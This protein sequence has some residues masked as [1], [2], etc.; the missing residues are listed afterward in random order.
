M[1]TPISPTGPAKL[2]ALV[3]KLRPL[4]YGTLMAFSGELVHGAFLRWLGSA[5]PEVAAWLHE[6]NKRRLFTCSNLGFPFSEGRMREA[7]HRSVH[8][9]LEP[10]QTYTVRLTLLLGELFP[11]FHKA[12]VGFSMQ[13]THAVKPPFIQLGRQLLL[14]E[15]VVITNDEPSGWTG[16]TSLS[17]L[18][19]Q[20][21][22]TRLERTTT[23]T[24]DF[25]SLTAFNRGNRK[26]GYGSHTVML[27]LPE[28]VFPNLARR[29]QDIAPP[30]LANVIQTDALTSYLQDDGVIIVDYALQAHHVHF[31]T[32]EQ[33]GF[34]GSCTYQLRG[35]DERT[36]PEALLTCG[37][38][39]RLLAELAFYSGVGYKTAMGLGQARLRRATDISAPT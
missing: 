26:T 38:Q 5:A 39:I 23:L 21:R 30:E 27:P 16:F 2:Y 24:L 1:E 34:I 36:N 12:L 11:L 9:P 33:R 10:E 19:E 15:E 17:H 32:H 7:E 28:Y 4:Q 13:K 14:L 6:G 8:L 29:W 3:L 37:Q 25:A 31:T 35:Q 18:V 22:Q 20:A